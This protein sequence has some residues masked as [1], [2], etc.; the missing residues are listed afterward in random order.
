MQLESSFTTWATNACF[1]S[2]AR[3]RN[4]PRAISCLDHLNLILEPDP[5]T[6]CFKVR[7]HDRAPQRPVSAGAK[8]LWRASLFGNRSTDLSARRHVMLRFP[9]AAVAL[10]LSI[11]V[12]PA[13]AGELRREVL[14]SRALGRD[15]PFL[16][17]V[18]DG[19]DSD[20]KYYPVLYLL[21]GAGD[22][23][24][25]WATRGLIL[26]KADQLIEKGV[27]PPTLIVM[28]GCPSC[29]WIDGPKDKAETAFWQEL[30]PTVAKR[31]RT[32]N[33]RDGRLIAGLS[34]GGYGTIR[35]VLR[36][37]NEIAAAAAFS[38][39]V[40]SVMPPLGSAARSHPAF[41]DKGKKF[42]LL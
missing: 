12:S 28:P 41:Q 39:A 1:R 7:S 31:Y 5:A 40:Y 15:L 22:D 10:I 35:F 2:S 21:H 26:E 23:E 11:F 27:I 30:V 8:H 24:N 33:S 3:A 25:A 13:T 9:L 18:P 4:F 20:T 32:I 16:V 17:Y 6:N 34:A 38:P 42:N 36:H 37:P 29:W 19:Y 14:P